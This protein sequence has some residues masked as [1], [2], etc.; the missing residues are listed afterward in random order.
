[1][2]SI[3]IDGHAK[4][5]ED[6]IKTNHL[7][8]IYD[9]ESYREI[10]K[11]KSFILIKNKMGYLVPFNAKFTVF[12]DNDFSNNY[13]IKAHLESRD[14]KSMY[15]YYILTKNDFSIDNI[16]SSAINLGLTMDLLKKYVIKLNLLIRT[17]RDSDLNL[18]EKYKN[19][20][21]EP[22]KIIWVY[23]HLIYPKDDSIK[24]KEKIENLIKD[25]KRNKFNLQIIEM[26][27][28]ENEIIGFVFKFVEMQKKK[29][30]KKDIIFQEFIPLQ[31]KEIIFDLLELRYIR[32]LIVL[33]KSGFRNY[34]DKN[35]EEKIKMDFLL[36]RKKTR[37]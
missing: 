6:F 14:A 10:E 31:K 8:N 13:V 20:E 29:K 36:K 33:K 17:S 12:D 23:P 5:V 4:K 9:K 24:N 19:F 15:A 25:S 3:F 35:D 16:S 7:N 27:Y 21:D 22:K 18:F 11:K 26:K 2:P 1:M 34:R 28:K 37:N 30:S 32:A